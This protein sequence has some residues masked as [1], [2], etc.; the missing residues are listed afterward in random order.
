MEGFWKAAAI[1]IL[2][3]VLGSA[4]GKTE[5]DLTVVLSLSA[6]CIILMVALQYLSDVL[7][8]LWELGNRVSDR[9]PFTGIL[10]RIAGVSL[11]TEVSSLLSSDAGHSSLG[12]AM[13]ILGNSVILF[14]SLPILEAFLTVIQE[15]M[16][17]S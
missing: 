10:M 2:T 4:I 16:G 11:V 8:F 12:K 15:I 6:C 7:A 9:N 3:V 17:C 14:L 5:K 13:Q 1:L